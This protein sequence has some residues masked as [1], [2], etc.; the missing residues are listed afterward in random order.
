MSME[1]RSPIFSRHISSA[2]RSQLTKLYFPREVFTASEGVLG[3]HTTDS[4]DDDINDR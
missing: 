1:S 3:S 4:R 2:V